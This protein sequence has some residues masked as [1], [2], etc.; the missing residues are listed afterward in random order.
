MLRDGWDDWEYIRQLR[1]RLRA[2]EAV[3]SGSSAAAQEARAALAEADKIVSCYGFPKVPNREAL[4]AQY[5]RNPDDVLPAGAKL[6][7]ARFEYLHD[8]RHLLQVRDRIA[9]AIEMFGLKPA[10]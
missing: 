8:P 3:G 10:P 5:H 2:V 1:E 4:I 9:R 7:P 6:D